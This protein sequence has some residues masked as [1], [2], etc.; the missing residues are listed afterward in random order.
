MGKGDY[1]KACDNL[2]HA[3]QRLYF[4]NQMFSGYNNAFELNDEFFC[5]F[6][7]IL[8]DIGDLLEEAEKNLDENKSE[9][10]LPDLK[11]SYELLCQG[12]FTPE[13]T[14]ENATADIGKIDRFLDNDLKEIITMKD[15]FQDIVSQAAKR[16]DL[17]HVAEKEAPAKVDGQAEAPSADQN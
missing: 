12:A 16:I 8:R 13:G 5:G 17:R 7:Q 10:S 1:I 11:F 3:R 15:K 6:T 2:N 9:I 14:I 4:I